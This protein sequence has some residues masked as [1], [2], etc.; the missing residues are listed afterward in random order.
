MGEWRDKFVPTYAIGLVFWMPAQAFNFAVLPTRMRVI[1]VGFC[2]YV[3]VNILAVMRRID[4]E[5]WLPKIG[6]VRSVD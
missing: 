4:I 5:K 1:Y 3:E 2:T 6:G